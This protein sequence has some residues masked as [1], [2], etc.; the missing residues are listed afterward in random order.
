MNLFKLS[1]SYIR[2]RKLSTIL[3]V[4]ILALGIATVVVLLILSTQVRDN[5]SNNSRGI[6]LVVGAKGSPMQLILAAVYHIDAPSGNIPLDEAERVMSDR[7]VETAIPMA[8]GD[9]YKG[10]RIVGTTSDYPGHYEADVSKGWLWTSEQ[11]ATIGFR[12]AQ[13]T[14]L[15]VGDTFE[16]SHGLTAA[17][18]EDHDEAPIRIVG[19]FA[20]TG[21]VVDQLIL[22]S[23]ETIWHVH[24]IEHGHDTQHG[25]GSEHGEE[26]ESSAPSPQGP[27]PEYTAILISYSSPMA[28]AVF[29]RWVNTETSLQAAAPA[30]ETS[31][32]FNMLGVGFDALRVFG[33]VL[34]L[35]A[36][37]AVF[38]ALV[39]ALKERRYD[40]AMMRTLGASR[41]RLM[42]H[43]LLEGQL[44]AGMGVVLG[45]ILGHSAAAFMASA[46]QES[47]GMALDGLA[48]VS[49]EGWIILLAMG[50]GLI[51]SLIPAFQAYRTD[52]SSTL[53][54]G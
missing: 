22:T 14:G 48:F 24:G 29:P 7:A 52:I 40:L 12:V 10:F 49:G 19:V 44:L 42:S 32:L 17:S 2:Q 28:A 6:D 36:L 13:E 34:I 11:E 50:A 27:A 54:E 45:L 35:A 8:L 53:A 43:V 41:F 23:I 4:L 16:S 9:S 1:A 33:V 51:A 15:S 3:N 30:Y 26:Q 25:N 31:R 47:R 20:E 21:T 38:V 18:G 5:L 37:L 46:V 39:N